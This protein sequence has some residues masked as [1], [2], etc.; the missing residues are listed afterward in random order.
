M[1]FGASVGH[2]VSQK[3]YSEWPCQH[4]TS[5]AMSINDRDVLLKEIEGFFL[6]MSLYKIDFI[7]QR[8]R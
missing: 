4:K 3:K 2:K 8:E 6:P 1:R 7:L 5:L